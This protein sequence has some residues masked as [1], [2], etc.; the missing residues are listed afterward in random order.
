M[1]AARV[2]A[3]TTYFGVSRSRAAVLAETL[4]ALGKQPRLAAAIVLFSTL[5]PR[6][7]PLVLH[8]MWSF[9]PRSQRRLVAPFARSFMPGNWSRRTF[10]PRKARRRRS[11]QP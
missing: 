10:G 7:Q 8:T 3:L 9:I 11:V 5:K 2:G 6:Y 1:W 4:E